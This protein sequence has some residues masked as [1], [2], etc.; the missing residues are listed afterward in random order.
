MKKKTILAAATLL[1]LSL[2][3]AFGIKKTSMSQNPWTE[4]IE[5]LCGTE[6]PTYCLA[7]GDAR[8]CSN[9]GF[10]FGVTCSIYCY[11]GFACCTLTG[12]YCI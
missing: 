1:V 8:H 9:E 6:Q 5:A 3:I 11:N 10:V 12:C 2:G 4:N 7:T